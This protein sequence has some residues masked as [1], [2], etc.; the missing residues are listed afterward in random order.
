MER[1]DPFNQ[2]G[3]QSTQ[4]VSTN[5]TDVS[6]FIRERKCWPFKH[7]RIFFKESNSTEE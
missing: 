7:L 5:I 2:K 3:Q 1:E 6:S 4:T